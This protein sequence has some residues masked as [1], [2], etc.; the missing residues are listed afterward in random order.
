MLTIEESLVWS[1][2]IPAKRGLIDT[3]ASAALF[4]SRKGWF[5]T[6]V[7]NND[8]GIKLILNKFAEDTKLCSVVDVL[9]LRD[10]IQRD[11]DR[12][13][14][15]DDKEIKKKMEVFV[16]IEQYIGLVDATAIIVTICVELEGQE[17]V[18]KHEYMK[19][20]GDSVDEGKA[21]MSAWSS[22]KPLTPPPMTYSWKSWQSMAG[23]GALFAGDCQALEQAAQGDDGVTLPGDVQEMTGCGTLCHYLVDNV[24]SGQRLYSMIVD[25][26]SN[27]NVSV[28][29]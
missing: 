9:E 20:R 5:N 4:F 10:A 23:T 24:V 15:Y 22:V 12:L 2:Y 28:I 25:E 19:G 17:H 13:E 1:N 26:F 6:F 7:S 11:P 21:V 16:V 8:S 14:R 29:L 27:L 3:A 18:T